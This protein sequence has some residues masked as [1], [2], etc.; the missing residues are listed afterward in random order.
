MQY[1]SVDAI[2]KDRVISLEDFVAKRICWLCT[3]EV[4]AG[5]I[6]LS[7]PVSE[8]IPSREIRIYFTCFVIDFFILSAAKIFRGTPSFKSDFFFQLGRNS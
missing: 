4:L 3:A 7:Q 8:L 5:D 6:F 2:W 1:N